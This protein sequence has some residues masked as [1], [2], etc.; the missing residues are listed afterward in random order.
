MR[1][2]VVVLSTFLGAAPVHAAWGGVR[3]AGH[4][5]GGR[6][7][8]GA[9][10]SGG[11]VPFGR[12]G[13]NHGIASR[14]AIERAPGRYYYHDEGGWRYWHYYGSGLHWYGFY[15]GPRFYWYPYW[16]GYWWWWDPAF[17]A[18]TFWWDG[19]WWYY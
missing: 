9:R 15:H 11:G 5:G 7:G 18:W 14:Q 3:P 13:F 17:A 19:Y 16:G 10:P 8:A 12:A 2:V 1:L 4:F 6:F